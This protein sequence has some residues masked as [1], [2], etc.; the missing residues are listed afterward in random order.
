M[1]EPTT[2]DKTRRELFRSVLRYIALGGLAVGG[3]FLLS[4]KDR[5]SACPTNGDCPA[6]PIAGRCPIET[7]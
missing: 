2:P 6:C 7:K 3:A 5:I 4:R 1:N